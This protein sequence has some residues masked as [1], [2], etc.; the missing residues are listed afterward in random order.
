MDLDGNFPGLVDVV[1]LRAELSEEMLLRTLA[2]FDRAIASLA[3]ELAVLEARQ[4]K[5]LLEERRLPYQI[6]ACRD[7]IASKRERRQVFS[8][9]LA[10]YRAREAAGTRDS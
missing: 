7:A 2:S 8:N 4:P 1:D 6:E 9:V 10:M 5:S 3:G